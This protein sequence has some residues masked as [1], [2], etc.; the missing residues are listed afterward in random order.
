M[1]FV[2]EDVS[3]NFFN[4]AK[5]QN[6]DASGAKTAVAF[7]GKHWFLICKNE[8]GN[9]LSMDHNLSSSKRKGG[10]HVN[11]NNIKALVY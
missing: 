8:K 4:F 3:G 11:W 10:T 1:G 2:Q 5:R 9:W 7:N 6:V